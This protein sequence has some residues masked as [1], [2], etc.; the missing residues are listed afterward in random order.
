MKYDIT[1]LSNNE[2]SDP[3]LQTEHGFSALIRFADKSLLFDCGAS[4]IFLDNAAVLGLE[5]AKA[6]AVVLSHGHYDHADGYAC[7]SPA[8]RTIIGGGFFRKRFWIDAV[9][10]ERH[11][12]SCSLTPAQLSGADVVSAPLTPLFDGVYLLYGFARECPFEPIDASNFVETPDG[13]VVDDYGDELAL[14]FDLGDRCAVLTGCGHA[15]AVN[16]CTFASR[17]LGKPVSEYIG[18]THLFA[19]Q[20]ERA[21]LTAEWFAQNGVFAAVCH[22]T[23]EDGARE[24]EK[25]GI[26]R[27]TGAGSEFV[28]R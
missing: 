8:P 28:L 26:L 6:D 24:F 1:I 20:P 16:I 5:P 25:R 18:G 7:L 17:L 22:C 27:K 19:Y 15:G 4:R 12:T 3:R 9:T 13:A 14:A 2:P 23:G 11:D 10:G 21:A